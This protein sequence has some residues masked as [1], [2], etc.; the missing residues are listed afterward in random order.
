MKKS[1]IQIVLLVII[2]VLVY[3]IFESIM[4]PVRFDKEKANREKAVIQRLKDI[5]KSQIAYKAVYRKYSNNFD[6]LV[7]FLK[8]GQFPVVFKKGNVPDSLTEQQAFNLGLITRDSIYISVLDSLFKN[9]GIAYIDSLPY[10]PFSEG[11]RFRLDAAEIEKS[12]IKVQVFEVFASKEHFLK[13]LDKEFFIRANDRKVGSMT[14]PS[15]DGN[16]E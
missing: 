9:K 11:E 7:D 13:G 1:I 16:W 14:E 10:I 6:T 4:K 15:T 2:I 8:N 5:R 12:M 3:M